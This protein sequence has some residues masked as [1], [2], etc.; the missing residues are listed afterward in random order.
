[1]VTLNG[2]PMLL[3]G[4]A[5]LSGIM[6]MLERFNGVL[7]QIDDVVAKLS[8]ESTG[9]TEW[10]FG[11]NTRAICDNSGRCV[12]GAFTQPRTAFA[13]SVRCHR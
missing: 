5:T 12:K 2:N 8:K 10:Q 1:V 9:S 6:S 4:D 7:I 13:V 11:Q 3:A